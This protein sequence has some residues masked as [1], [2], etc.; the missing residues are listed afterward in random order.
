MPPR[1]VSTAAAGRRIV[2]ATAPAT[3]STQDG[4]AAGR[5][6]SAGGSLRSGVVSRITW[7][8][9]TAA[10]PSTI[11]WWVFVTTATRPPSRPS[12]R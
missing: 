3:S 2:S 6:V 5:Q 4:S 7:P 1:T 11:A 10:T 9:S 8:M 12:T